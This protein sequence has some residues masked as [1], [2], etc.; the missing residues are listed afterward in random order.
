MC[1]DCCCCDSGVSHPLHNL[2]SLAD[3]G[4]PFVINILLLEVVYVRQCSGT[5]LYIVMKDEGLILMICYNE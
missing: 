1:G 2:P 5:V 3:E 4:L